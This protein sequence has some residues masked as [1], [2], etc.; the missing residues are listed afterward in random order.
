ME[1]VD[2]VLQKNIDRKMSTKADLNGFCY[3][4]NPD[5]EGD[6]K[7]LYRLDQYNLKEKLNDL[8]GDHRECQNSAFGRELKNIYDMKNVYDMKNIHDNDVNNIYK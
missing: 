8:H 5:L 4:K 1:K 2:H 3:N 6:D 7:D